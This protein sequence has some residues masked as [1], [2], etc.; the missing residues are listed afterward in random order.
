MATQRGSDPRSEQINAA[1]VSPVAV[2]EGRSTIPALP[3]GAT[4]VDSHCHLDM[5]DYRDD[6]G[7]VVERAA[8]HGVTGI[9]TIGIDLASSRQAVAIAERFTTVRATVGIHP[10]HADD[11]DRTTL[12][13][14]AGLAERYR[15]HVVGFGEIGLDYVKRHAT[16]ERQRSALI[17]QLGLAK[18]LKLPIVIHDREAHDD[19]LKLLQ[20]EGPFEQGGVM[21]CFSG[22]LEFARI[23][24]DTNLHISIP[25]IVTFKSARDL[26]AV[27]AHIPLDRLLVETDGPFLAP[28]PF[29]GKRNEPLYT[30][31]TAAAIAN[32]QGVE[33]S[34]I[35]RRTSENARRLFACTFSR[36]EASIDD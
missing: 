36:E 18:E 33:L 16:P 32:L 27:A 23:V 15:Q 6:L 8:R 2:F 34:E 13:A 28:V 29:R 19:C 7:Q 30:L 3:N 14:L 24:L 4:L 31:Y 1:T 10:H 9:V 5:T 20:S 35:A 25:G 12:D 26:Q 17:K 21:H 11:V 22:D